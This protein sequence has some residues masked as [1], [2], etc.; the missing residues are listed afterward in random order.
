MGRLQV[1]EPISDVNKN[2]FKDCGI[3][4]VGDGGYLLVLALCSVSISQGYNCVTQVA[5]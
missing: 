2:R 1:C 4:F 3:D 5:S